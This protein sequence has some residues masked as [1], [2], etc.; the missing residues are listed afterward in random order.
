MDYPRGVGH[1][2]RLGYL[3]GNLQNS[4]ERQVFLRNQFTQGLA[5]NE[6]RRDKVDLIYF[7]DFVNRQDVRMIQS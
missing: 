6:F 4:S 7:A 2:Q 1:S 5:V 3:D